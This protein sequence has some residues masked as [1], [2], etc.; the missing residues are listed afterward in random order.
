MKRIR[1]SSLGGQHNHHTWDGRIIPG[2]GR[3]RAS[4]LVQ[5][6]LAVDFADFADFAAESSVLLEESPEGS[7]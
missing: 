3:I 2:M 7:D 6:E 5:A 1:A 4:S